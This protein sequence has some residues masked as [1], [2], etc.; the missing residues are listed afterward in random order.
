MRVQLSCSLVHACALCSK[1]RYMLHRCL[2]LLRDV[3]GASL[4]AGGAPTWANVYCTIRGVLAQFALNQWP[5]I[6]LLLDACGQRKQG[7]GCA[8]CSSDRVR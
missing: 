7:H 3:A 2:H 4:G 6:L 1:R 5:R 8:L